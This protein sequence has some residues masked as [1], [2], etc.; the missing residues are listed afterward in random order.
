MKQKIIDLMH[1]QFAR[2]LQVGFLNATVHFGV[3]NLVYFALQTSRLLASIVATIIAMLMSFFV[4][5]LYVFVSVEGRSLHQ[6][7]LRFLLVTGV[8]LLLI[9]NTVF[10]IVSQVASSLI[11]ATA[12]DDFLI[13]N[14]STVVAAL[15]ALV[16]NYF[17]YK[18]LVFDN[19]AKR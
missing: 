3:L 2:F 5:R 6:E 7:F 1:R 19:E 17:G 18:W 13:L 14:G 9:H 4:N 11:P 16:W 15:V 10:Y 8:G 12:L